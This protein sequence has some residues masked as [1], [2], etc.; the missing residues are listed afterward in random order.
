MEPLLVL[1]LACPMECT[2]GDVA[3]NCIPT[4][5]ISLPSLIYGEFEIVAQLYKS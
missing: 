4:L 3:S 1:S 5:V 2:I